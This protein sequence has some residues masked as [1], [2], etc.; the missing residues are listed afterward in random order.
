MHAEK[1]PICEG[2]R[3]I[4]RLDGWHCHEDACHGCNGKGWVEVSDGPQYTLEPLPCAPVGGWR[5]FSDPN[6]VYPPTG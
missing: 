3:N 6:A 1:C 5:F 4:P 2:K